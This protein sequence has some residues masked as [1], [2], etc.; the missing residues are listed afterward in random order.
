MKKFIL[1][2]GVGALLMGATACGKSNAA[3][4][5]DA[6]LND[7]VSVLFGKVVG[8]Q[9]AENFARQNDGKVDKQAFL[10][11]IQTAV[12]ADSTQESY[13]QG[14]SMGV[15]FAQQFNYFTKEMG[16]DVDRDLFMKEFKAAFT[17]DSVSDTAI[18]QALLNS[19]ME[20]A[21]KA[22][23]ERKLEELNNAPEAVAGRKAGEAFIDSIKKADPTVKTT[24][25]GLS[26][27]VISEGEGD[28]ITDNDQVAVIYKGTLTDGSVFDDSKGEARNF[29]PTQVVPGFGEGLKLMKKGAKYVL[30]IPGDLAYGVKGQPYANIGPNQTLVFDV[31]IADIN[32]TKK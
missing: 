5:G 15:R 12:S 7:S 6:A 29:R 32:P 2:C 14:L 4:T 17:A 31:E 18:D 1:A 28:A 25:S 19:L 20:R 11:G 27:K 16:V 9:F 13:L 8:N 30:Y 23:E 21:Q 22:A 3:T 26:Y 24:A 10:R